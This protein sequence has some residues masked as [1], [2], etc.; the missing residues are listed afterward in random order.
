MDK[1]QHKVRVSKKVAFEKIKRYY[2]RNTR[3]VIPIE[4]IQNLVEENRVPK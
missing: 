1:T 4:D 2:E 3:R